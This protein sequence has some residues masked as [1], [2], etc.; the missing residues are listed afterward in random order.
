[1]RDT[2]YELV[3]SLVIGFLMVVTCIGALPAASLEWH[4]SSGESIQTAI[5]NASDGDTI[6]VHPGTYVENVDVN[7]RITL[8]GDGADVV[9]V[10]AANEKDHVFEVTADLVNISGFMVRGAKSGKAGI[11]LS[12]VECCNI[13]WNNASDTSKAIYLDHSERNKLINNNVSRSAFGIYLDYS[14]SNILTKNAVSYNTREGISLQHSSSNRLTNNAASNSMYGI[15]LCHSGNNTLV[16]NVIWENDYNFNVIGESLSEYTNYIDISNEVDGKPIYYWVGEDEREIPD[17][18]GYVGVVNSSNITV[19]DLTLRGNCQGVL[20]SYTVNS[21]IENVSVSGNMDG[22]HL[23]HS[24]H[25]QVRDN[26]VSNNENLGIY[27]FDVSCN[28]TL[29]YNIVSNNFRDGIHQ[30]FSNYNTIANNT[31]VSNSQG[32]SLYAS[33]HNRL[34]HN[35][36]RSSLQYGIWLSSSNNNRIHHNNLINNSLFNNFNAYDRNG[37]NEWDSGAEGNYYSDYTGTDP[38]GD[39]I[40]KDPY[41][42]P[43][44]KSVDRYPLMEPW[45]SQKKGDVDGD[46]NVE[47]T[48]VYMLLNHVGDPVSHPIEIAWSGDVNSDG[49]IDMGDVILLLNHVNDPVKYGLGD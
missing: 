45:E 47:M 31:V 5:D 46:T 23:K 37:T 14:T 2:Q 34:T 9:T 16:K 13:S 12:G 21:R 49:V 44:G 41:P 26:T 32:I 40:G 38:D 1:M 27:L 10:R 42:I 30:R 8:I 7:K 48:D 3:A 15:S 29:A 11:Y 4:V 43:G 33:N 18:A 25:T 39:G 6:Y 19:R 36:V 20:F 22:I 17:D 28:N 24:N 35:T